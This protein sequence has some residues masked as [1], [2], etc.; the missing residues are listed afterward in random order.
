MVFALGISSKTNGEKKNFIIFF[1][2]TVA[3]FSNFLQRNLLGVTISINT[4]E[5]IWNLEG[6]LNHFLNKRMPEE[7][8]P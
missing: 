4:A 3:F 6:F 1:S 5:E 7:R 8:I 2:Y